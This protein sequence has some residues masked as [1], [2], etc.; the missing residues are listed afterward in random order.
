MIINNKPGPLTS[1]AMCLTATACVPR[2][3][4][5]FE[6][7]T[8]AGHERAAQSGKDA[9]GAINGVLIRVSSTAVGFRVSI[10]SPDI[11]IAR[12]LAQSGRAL[13]ANAS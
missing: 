12:Q 11:D 6:Q 1:L 4:S 9:A 3:S 13:M 2:Q 5:A 7:M 8:A 10:T